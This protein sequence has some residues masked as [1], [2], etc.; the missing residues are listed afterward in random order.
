MAKKGNIRKNSNGKV[1]SVANLFLDVLIF[2]LVIL[3]IYMAY[4]LFLK[5]NSSPK[6]IAF[7]PSKETP[8]EII[9]VEVLNGCGIAGL[10]ERF[11]DY[12][13][14]KKVDV[15]N[16][17]NFDSFDVPETIVIDRS[18][19]LANAKKIARLLGVPKKNIS[20]EIDKNIL[21]DV[22]VIIGRDYAKLKPI[23]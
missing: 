17:S 10:A 11:T 19:N 5:F 8:S 14:E 4:S 22:T 13:R 9:Q 23:K 18:G 6:I 21:L 12:L 7:N 3:I 2:V 16:M 1:S 15:V 20:Q